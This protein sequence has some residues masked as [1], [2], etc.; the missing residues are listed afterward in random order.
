MMKMASIMNMVKWVCVILVMVKWV[1]ARPYNPEIDALMAFK[2]SLQDPLHVL[3]SWDPNLVDPCTYF[4]IT[5][6][7]HN[8]VTRIDLAL[9]NL[10]GNLV[11]DLGN[12]QQLQ[13]LELYKNNIQGPIWPELGNLPNLLS[14]D[15][16]NNNISGIIPPELGKISSLL[17]LRID[18]NKL[19]GPIPNELTNLSKLRILDV[20]SNDLCGAI[21]TGGPFDHI[22]PENFRNNPRLGGPSP[23]C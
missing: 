9:F 15:L 19:S 13:Y 20:S 2:Q 10:T 18:D 6:D 7:S 11:P 1:S 22:P 4:H 17:F 8:H 5:C 14:L 3:D 12:L 16:Y 23:N 21:P